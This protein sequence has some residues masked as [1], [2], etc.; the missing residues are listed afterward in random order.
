MML[1]DLSSTTVVLTGACG[2]LGRVVTQ[3]LVD[4]G[5]TV[6]GLDTQEREPLAE[7]VRLFTADLTGEDAVVAVFDRIRAEIGS[8]GALIHTVGMW[9]GQP[10]AET[11]FADWNR[12]M[13]VNLTSAF[14]TFREAARH[15]QD[16]GGRL[17]GIASRQGVERGVGKQAA[18]SMAKAGVMRLVEAVA[19]EYE[20]HITAAAVAPSTILF[21][22]EDA[23]VKGVAV[24]DVAALCVY[25][26]GPG[27]SVHNGTVLRAYG[28]G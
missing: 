6:A 2:R 26:C 3:H 16:T 5:A 12:V 17:V 4:A 19:D 7:G 13:Q 10:F 9:D 18:Y 20:G 14:L 28:T 25:L 1:P 24:D 27:G 23:E 15:M 22:E 8:V 11:S 21:G